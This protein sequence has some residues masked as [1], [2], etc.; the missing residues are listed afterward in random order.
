MNTRT[1]RKLILRDLV[2]FLQGGKGNEMEFSGSARGAV[3]RD[4]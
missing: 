2:Y 1:I 3:E 4:F